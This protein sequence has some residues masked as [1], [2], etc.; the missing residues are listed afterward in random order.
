[1]V[2]LGVTVPAKDQGEEDVTKIWDI[3]GEAW[4]LFLAVSGQWRT[5]ASGTSLI[6][7]GLDFT[8]V[9]VAMRRLGIAD[10]VFEDVVS[11]EDAALLAFAGQ[12]DPKVMHG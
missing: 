4:R 7:L 1:M 9:D 2:A 8:A 10:H 5:T 3:N 11:M 12:P 6:Q